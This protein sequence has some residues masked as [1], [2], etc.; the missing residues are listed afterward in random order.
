ML[1]VKI[2][3]ISGFAILACAAQWCSPV[4]AQ[5]LVQ[6][7]RDIQPILS[8][9]CYHCHGPDENAREADLR[10]DTEEGIFAEGQDR[11]IVLPGKHAESELYHRV[12]SQEK[13]SVMPPPES[14]LTLTADQ[15]EKI[16]VWID[17]GAKWETLWSLV[18][19]VK[20][21]PPVPHRS[22]WT[23]DVIDSFIESR[24]TENGLEHAEEEGKEKLIRRVY[25]DLLGIPP[26]VDEIDQ[27][28]TDDSPYAYEKIVDRLLGS[29]RYGERMAWPW[30]D[31]ARYADSNGFQG[32]RERTM[33]P[34]RDWVIDSL[35]ANL[36]FNE[37]TVQQIAGD[38]LPNAS[39]PDRLATGFCRNH[40]INGEGGR[41]AEENRVEYI[42]DQI[43]TVGTVWLGLTLNCCRCHDHKYDP[44]LQ[45][46]YYALFGI[47]NR[48]PVNGGGG[49]PAT[50]PRMLASSHV[51]QFRLQELEPVL[52]DFRKV[53]A[54]HEARIFK[55]KQ[56]APISDSPRAVSLEDG[57][58]KIL[59]IA[60]SS[61]NSKQLLALENHFSKS[62][63]SY[64]ASLKNLRL[65]S[66]QFNV[67]QARA[68]NV[69]IME[70][71][72]VRKTFRLERGLYNQPKEEV[73]AGLPVAFSGKNLGED[74]TR[75]SLARFLVGKDN[76]LTARVTVNRAWQTIFGTGL[77]RTPEDF[78]SQ[79]DKPSHPL[80]L[81][82]LAVEFVDSEWDLKSLHRKLVLSAAYRQSAIVKEKS[83]EVDPENRL[84]S[85]SPRYRMPAWMIRDHA[86][87]VSELM[88]RSIGGASVKPYQPAGLWSEATFNKKKYTQDHG[89]K[90]YRSSLYTFWRRIVG[91]SM[92]FDVAKRQ[93]CE[94]KVTRTNSPLH[95]LVTLN[96]VTFVEAARVTAE[97]VWKSFEKPEDRIQN[98]FRRFTSRRPTEQESTILMRR[99]QS[100]LVSFEADLASV[101]NLLDVGEISRSSSI[102][103]GDLAGLAALTDV[104]LMVMN[105]DESLSK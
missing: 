98:A 34:W 49:D 26:T 94:V 27:F 30:L 87:G 69:M 51:D 17:T 55:R 78:G 11:R 48:T 76:P 1:P 8:E 59:P 74:E 19:P 3:L 65:S 12:F 6:F 24:L 88:N 40:M 103:T 2:D 33:W 41:I 10:L 62:E 58:K 35:N 52:A 57:L 77:L 29:P 66:D 82:W 83:L 70:D 20:A 22:Q 81:D 93:S 79:G 75:L 90:L 44:L 15:R 53:V 95:A 61:R 42:F 97:R 71:S 92:L 46:D 56:G 25:L 104:C 60:A 89:E 50:P 43:E 45:K 37:F 96:D 14:K 9:N 38:L 67:I 47:F 105:L 84:L 36:P 63:K 73:V 91:P 5:E 23:R 32:D 39:S 21:T 68:G 101:N 102:S 13:D 80:L 72:K 64:A 85:Y 99:F 31:A 86:L 4:F 54:D 100:A 7:S 28:L 16:K 18:P